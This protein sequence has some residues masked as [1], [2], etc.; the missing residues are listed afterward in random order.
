MKSDGPVEQQ[1]CLAH[2]NSSQ[3]VVEDLEANKA[4]FG[5]LTT[6]FVFALHEFYPDSLAEIFHRISKDRVVQEFEQVLLEI[7][8]CF[9]HSSV[10]RAM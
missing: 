1:L 3:D 10:F 9:F 2:M 7:R 4:W 5:N 8:P 6:C